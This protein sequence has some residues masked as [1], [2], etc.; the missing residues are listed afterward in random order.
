MAAARDPSPPKVVWIGASALSAG[1]LLGLS[2]QFLRQIDGPLTTLGGAIAPWLTVGFSVAVWATRGRTFRAGSG[3]AIATMAAYLVAWLFAYHATFAIREAAT[4]AGAWREAAPWVLI[5]APVSV[6]LGIVAAITHR[7]GALGDAAVALP[8]AWSIPEIAL[9]VT[10][11]PPHVI[12]AALPTSL[13]ALSP[14]LVVDRR[15]VKLVR[16]AAACVVFGVG[17]MVA[18]PVA[19]SLIH[20]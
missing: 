15:D 17:A 5:A 8:V 7:E 13:V 20:S 12:V 10:G 2:A 16:V 18:L 1:L 9:F 14:L 3:I 6:V 11:G 4:P 19:R